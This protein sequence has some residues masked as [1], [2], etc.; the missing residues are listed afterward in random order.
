MILLLSLGA[1]STGGIVVPLN[2]LAS[3]FRVAGIKAVGR[4]L[5]NRKLKKIFVAED[6][7]PNRVGD[8][9]AEA[10]D[11]GIQ[12]E[13]TESSVYLGRACAINRP[14]SVAGLKVEEEHSL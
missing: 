10:Q 9:V 3:S 8:L 7:D 5:R 13:F 4:A 11:Q 12:I 1:F 2:E 6:V 14:A